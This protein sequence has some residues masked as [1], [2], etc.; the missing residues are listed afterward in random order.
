MF[1]IRPIKEI[2][3]RSVGLSAEALKDRLVAAAFEHY[4][5]HPRDDDVTL[6]VRKVR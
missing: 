2:L 4:G 1:G 6:V 5:E 3:E